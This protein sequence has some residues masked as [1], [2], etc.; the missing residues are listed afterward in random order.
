MARGGFGGGSS[1]GGG[2]GGAGGWSIGINGGI[3]NADQPAMNE[4]IKRANSGTHG[5]VST[6]QMTTAYDVEP[7]IT[8]RVDGSVFALQLRPGYFYEN[9]GGSGKNGSYEMSVTGWTIFPILRLYPLENEYMKFYLQF[10]LGYGRMNGEINEGAGNQVQF[11]AGAFGTVVG[12][13]SEFCFTPNHCVNIEGD[14]RYLN[15]ERSKVT[16]SSGTLPDLTA[17]GKDHELE[18]DDNDMAV[19]MGGLE[20]LAGYTFYF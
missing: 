9:E 19:R 11:A 15:F 12:L 13:G 4:I 17:Y 18:M 3:I 1:S 8:Y 2:G 10:G 20:F 6:S 5:P 14:Y 7:F 16:K